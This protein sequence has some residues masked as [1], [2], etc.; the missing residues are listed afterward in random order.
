MAGRR[1][2]GRSGFFADT[3]ASR[4][5]PLPLLWACLLGCDIRPGEKPLPS[6]TRGTYRRDFCLSYRVAAQPPAA[7]PRWALAGIVR[8][9]AAGF[10]GAGEFRIIAKVYI[11]KLR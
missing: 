5:T 3:Y 11:N 4:S 1:S 2:Q 8:E 10:S 9:N 6:V 7:A